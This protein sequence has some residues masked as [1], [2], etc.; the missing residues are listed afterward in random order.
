MG[1]HISRTQ[2]LSTPIPD[3]DR[4]RAGIVRAENSIEA[5][6][7]NDRLW[8]GEGMDSS[9]SSPQSLRASRSARRCVSAKMRS[10]RAV[11]AIR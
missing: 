3:N 6:S 10:R 4:K 5:H 7:Q 11:A 8:N 2:R 1:G 9:V